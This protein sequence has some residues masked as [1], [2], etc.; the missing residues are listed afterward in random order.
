MET[1]A[2]YGMAIYGRHV[3]RELM[4]TDI[5]VNYGIDRKKL[6][7]YEGVK[8]IQPT[9]RLPDVDVIINCVI[10]EHDIVAGLLHKLIRC[11]VVSLEDVVF[12]SY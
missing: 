2:I 3:V 10:H 6:G 1:I 8:I 4:G 12:A 7:E 11:P 5:V 9:D